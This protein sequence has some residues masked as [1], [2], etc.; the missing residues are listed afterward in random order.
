MNSDKP[1]RE[2]T[3]AYWFVVGLLVGALA[4]TIPLHL[5]LKEAGL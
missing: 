3:R 2:N 1:R 4:V 5:I